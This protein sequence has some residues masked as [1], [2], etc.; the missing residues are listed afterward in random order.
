[1]ALYDVTR[2][3]VPMLNGYSP[4][5]PRRYVAEV[6]EPLQGLNAGDLGPAEYAVLRRL[7]VTHLVLDR[8]LFAPEASPFP[9][10]FTRDRLRSSP[11]LAL[12][13]AADPLWL[14]RLTD[15]APM[16]GPPATSPVGQFFEAEALPHDTGDLVDDRDASGA[17]GVAARAGAARP[18]FL[19]F[20]PYRMLPAGAYRAVFRV[21]GSGLTVEITADEGRRVLAQRVL[22]PRPA[23]DEVEL[24]FEVEGARPLEYRVRW[25][26]VGDG[27]VDWVLV[28]FADRPQPEWTFEVEDLPHKLGER[29]DPAASGGWAAY[30]D[31]VESL[32]T[33]LVSGPARL[34]PPGRYRLTLHARTEG[35]ARG[36]VLRLSVTE[37]QGRVLAARTVDAGELPPG[38][39]RPVG[40]DFRLERPTV[41][42]FP[43]GYLGGAG[44]HFDRLEVIPGSP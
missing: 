24:P 10:A 43:V 19:V 31:P 9:S 35:T 3:R 27:A 1:V 38:H 25:N 33:D 2:T 8:A 34:Y 28:A 6:F 39:Y 42:E 4:L 29:P 15:E 37:P 36:P 23:W 21:R 16:I 5:V 12:D 20:G 32:R 14:Y 11:A 26:G 7:G 18:G 13:R 41:I 30:A 17:R 44:V 40:L 22:E